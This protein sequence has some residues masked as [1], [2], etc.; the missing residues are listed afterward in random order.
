LGMAEGQTHPLTDLGR[1]VGMAVRE[2][3]G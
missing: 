3:G 1:G 2:K